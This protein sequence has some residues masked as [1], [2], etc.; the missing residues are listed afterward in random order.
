MPQMFWVDG[1]WPG[2]LAISSRPRGGDWLAEEVRGWRGAGIDLVLS[3]LSR[4]EEEELGLIDEGRL[5]AEH[6]IRFVSFPI[7]DR[8]VPASLEATVTLL[9]DLRNT[10]E[11]GKKVVVHCRQGIGRSALITAGTL[12]TAGIEPQSALETVASARG[13]PV[14]ETPEQRAWVERVL[15]DHLALAPR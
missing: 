6:G 14:P 5:A 3:L 2:R 9:G 1:P 4:E 8:G 13:L 15:G 12:V 10:L 7:A 11:A